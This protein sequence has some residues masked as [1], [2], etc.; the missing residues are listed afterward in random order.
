MRKLRCA[1]SLS[2]TASNG[3]TSCSWRRL[4]A[5]LHPVVD[6]VDDDVVAVAVNSH[7]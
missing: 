1:G 5:Q 6:S 4:R 3:L 7:A 2:A